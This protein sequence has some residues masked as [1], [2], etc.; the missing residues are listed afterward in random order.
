[1][2]SHSERN[3]GFLGVPLCCRQ[4]GIRNTDNQIRINR[5]IPGKRP[6]PAYPGVID[7]KSVYRAVQS[8]KIDIFKDAVRQ[9]WG[10]GQKIRMELSVP[11][12]CQNLSG[13][14]IPDK[15]RVYGLQRTALG[16]QDIGMIPLSKTDR[17]QPIGISHADQ[18]SG[19]HKNQRISALDREKSLPNGCLDIRRLY[20]LSR[21]TIGNDLRINRCMKNRAGILHFFT[22]FK[23]VYQ[24]SIMGKSQ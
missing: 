5:K 13:L 15:F 10:F 2:E 11:T 19:T 16:S 6:S 22:E 18:L 3:P 24:I 21:N 8:G 9:A 17:L 1:M 23:R 12:D 20:P 14:Q 7:R 4:T